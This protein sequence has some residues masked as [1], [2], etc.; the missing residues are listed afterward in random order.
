[1]NK[2]DI[3]IWANTILAIIGTYLNAKQVRLGFLVW[4][5]TNGVFVVYNITLHS[6]QQ[7]ALFSVY[8][9]LAIFG[10]VNWGKNTKKSV[11]KA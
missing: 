10:W 8:V 3:F 11:E 2:M 9:G 5:L 7:A 6:Y 1:M 4:M